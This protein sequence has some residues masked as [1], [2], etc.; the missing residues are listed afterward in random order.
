MLYHLIQLILR[1]LLLDHHH[2]ITHVDHSLHHRLILLEYPRNYYHLGYTL[3]AFPLVCVSQQMTSPFYLE[4]LSK[5]PV[6]IGFEEHRAP[7]SAQTTL[8]LPP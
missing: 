7:F 5:I 8:Y 2:H 3:P 1:H 4:P 6:H